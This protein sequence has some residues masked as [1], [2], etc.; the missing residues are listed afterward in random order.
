MLSLKTEVESQILQL[1]RDNESFGWST[2]NKCEKSILRVKQNIIDL[3]RI[4]QRA[5]HN[6]DKDVNKNA[7]GKREMFPP[8]D[9]VEPG[10]S[11]PV[12]NFE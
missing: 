2:E 6:H 11:N 3:Y 7:P 12:Q 1:A 8:L 4:I 5:E 10:T 9:G